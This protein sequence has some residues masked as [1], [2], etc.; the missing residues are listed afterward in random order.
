[1]TIHKPDGINIP[2]GAIEKW[3]REH[4]GT[5]VSA[6]LPHFVKDDA[7]EKKKKMWIVLRYENQY[8][9]CGG[10]FTGVFGSEFACRSPNGHFGRIGSENTW[11]EIAKVEMGKLYNE[12][13]IVSR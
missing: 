11:Y 8:D 2:D 3:F 13:D 7:W 12:N 4:G 9:Q 1:M 5:V 10:Y 6:P